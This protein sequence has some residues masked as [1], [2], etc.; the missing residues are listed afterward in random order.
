MANFDSIDILVKRRNDIVRLNKQRVEIA[1]KY[2]QLLHDFGFSDVFVQ[3]GAW[4]YFNGVQYFEVNRLQLFFWDKTFGYQRMHLVPNGDVCIY[5]LVD[6][7][8]LNANGLEISTA[9][10][11]ETCVAKT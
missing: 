8:Y 10:C 6:V 11:I 9:L 3:P 5:T 4:Y 2:T 7:T 1:T